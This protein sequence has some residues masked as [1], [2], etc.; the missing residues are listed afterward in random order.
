[1]DSSRFAGCTSGARTDQAFSWFALLV[2]RFGQQ[3]RFA[4]P[5]ALPAPQGA[6]APPLV[7]A[8]GRAC[9]CPVHEGNEQSPRV[10][11]KVSYMFGPRALREDFYLG[12]IALLP[13]V[14]IFSIRTPASTRSRAC[15]WRCA[16]PSGVRAMNHV[17]HLVQTVSWPLSPVV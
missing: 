10:S 4:R 17:L 3:C 8:L 15:T 7:S 12:A 11:T 13:E 14:Y 2:C 9:E 16:A 6:D 5:G 1:M